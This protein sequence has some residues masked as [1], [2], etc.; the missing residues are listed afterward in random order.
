MTGSSYNLCVM[1]RYCVVVVESKNPPLKSKPL[2]IRQKNIL[3]TCNYNARKLGV[4]KL[5]L[6]TEAKRLCP[7][8]VLVDGEDLTPFRDTSKILFNFLRSHSWNH[9]VERLGFDEVFMDVTDMVEYNIMCLNQGSLADS[10]FYL[11]KDNPLLGFS[12]DLTSVAGCT[13]GRSAD[14]VD[15]G[16]LSYI[17]LVLGSH[18]GNYLRTRI[19]EDFGYTSTCGI[20]TNKLLSKLVGAKNK[21]RNQTTLIALCDEDA[22]SFVN[23]HALRAIPG[24]GSR[25]TDLIESH[26]LS[27][28]NQINNDV[29]ESAVTAGQARI[30]PSL[31]PGSI[32]T[33]LGSTGAEHGVGA[34]IWGL[35]HGV[36]HAEVK[37]AAEFPTQISIE[38]TYKGIETFRQITEELHKLSLS[39]IRRMRVELLVA[40][41]EEG[42]SDGKKWIAKPKTLR[43]SLRSWPQSGTYPARDF[44]RTSR[45]GPLPNFVFEIDVDVERIAERLVTE[46]LLPLLRRFQYEKGHRWNLQLINI[47]VANMNASAER[48]I[49]TMFR[50]QDEVLKPWR[51]SSFDDGQQEDVQIAS[52]DDEMEVAVSWESGTLTAFSSTTVILGYCIMARGGRGG[53]QQAMRRSVDLTGIISLAEKN[54]LITLVNAITEKMHNDISTIFDSPPVAPLRGAHGHHHWLS[55]PLLHRHEKKMQA[56]LDS[57]V[58]DGSKTYDKAHHIIEKEETDAMTPQLR[59]LKKEALGFYSPPRAPTVHVDR[60]L[61]ARYVPIPN[62]LWKLDIEKRKLLLHIVFLLLLSLSEYT[63]NTRLLLLNLASSLNLPLDVLQTEEV[64][65]ARGFAQ[66]A[67]DALSEDVDEPKTEEIKPLKKW[68]LGLGSSTGPKT[69]GNLAPPLVAIGLGSAHS[70]LGLPC[71]AAAALLGAMAEH[72]QLVGGLFGMIG[73]KSTIKAMESFSRE[74]QD[75]AFLRLHDELRSE[76][77][78]VRQIVAQDRRLRIVIAM[79]GWLNDKDDGVVP[80]RCLGSQAETF[81]VR[82]EEAVLMNLGS[83]LETVIKSTAWS[84]AKEEIN[85]RTI[86][87]SLMESEWPVSLLKI[88]KII[89]NPWS[90]GMV[91]AEKAGAVLADAIMRSKF[92]GDRPVSL[93][94]YSLAS[95]AI[96]TCLMVLAERRQFGIVDSVVMMGTPAPSESRVWLTLKSVV[97]GRLV[98]VYSEQDFMLG[99]LYRTSNIQFGVAGLQ[100]VQG[101]TGVENHCVSNMPRAHLGYQSM[102]GQILKDIGWEDVRG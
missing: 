98:N 52:D 19:E 55:L 47:C 95:R 37:E 85:S 39:L 54:D 18:L 21:P 29:T 67:L 11:S 101:A 100:E 66:V 79:S 92:Q 59:E 87:R 3:A 86:F 45:S 77:R 97:S 17:R 56:A 84:R 14:A 96:Y 4:R 60:R 61:A 44:S 88:S 64:R 58:G 48:D 24:I 62:P 74:I 70:G 27:N 51:I 30:H 46:A 102:L 72:G 8:L 9:K 10:F 82:W 40:D 93:I 50:K 32:E 89:D 80:W 23:G 5:M 78:D 13:E 76:Y 6:A 57:H 31:S 7:E 20:S 16:D 91:R 71:S 65:L 83:S 42:R 69:S 90:M 15:G 53:N 63:A 41:E 34:R 73:A 36:D 25:Y 1:S 81:A 22:I 2:G 26:I 35:L 12:C 33:L 68:K 38:D 94:G 75:F 43:L 28:S 49:S 99:F